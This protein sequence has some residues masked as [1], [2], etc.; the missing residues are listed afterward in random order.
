VF[1]CMRFLCAG[2]YDGM[3]SSVLTHA[4]IR[5]NGLVTPDPSVWAD[6]MVTVIGRSTYAAAAAAGGGG[7]GT[8][9]CFGTPTKKSSLL[10][11]GTCTY[12]KPYSNSLHSAGVY[13]SAVAPSCSSPV[14]IRTYG[15]SECKGTPLQ[16]ET[17]PSRQVGSCQYYGCKVVRGAAGVAQPCSPEKS[18]YVRITCAQVL[19]A[20]TRIQAGGA[21][22]AWSL[23][24]ALVA[25]CTV[26]M[27]A[28]ACS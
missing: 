23:A 6:S 1:M 14:V 2:V 3:L 18:E 8:T 16:T 22:T 15:N 19:S 7:D 12:T 11:N 10:G 9:R 26:A 24:Q 28:V 25:L 5:I 21:G 20:A 13:M 17:I 27:A 4:Q